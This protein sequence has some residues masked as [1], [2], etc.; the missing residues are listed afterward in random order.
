LIVV[1]LDL[2]EQ[3]RDKLQTEEGRAFCSFYK[4]AFEAAKDSIPAEIGR[5]RITDVKCENTQKEL[6]QTFRRVIHPLRWQG[7][8]KRRLWNILGAV[9]KGKPHVFENWSDFVIIFRSI[10]IAVEILMPRKSLGDIWMRL[11]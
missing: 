4:V 9:L 8:T 3:I 5:I 6:F 11:L 1:G 10:L 2:Y 7:Q